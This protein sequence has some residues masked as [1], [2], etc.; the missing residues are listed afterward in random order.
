MLHAR[1]L[2][3]LDEVARTGSI[4]QAAGRLNV[5]ASAIN[6]QILALEEEIG[7]PLFHR[8]PRKLALTAA[9]E[10]LIRHIRQTLREERAAQEKIEALKGLHGGEVS[11]ALMSGLAANVV[12]RAAEAFR[13]AHPRAKLALRL[14]PTGEDIVAAISEGEADLGLGFDFPAA[15]RLR[16]LARN[17]GRLGCVMAP[18]HPFAARAELRIGDCVEQPLVIADQSMVIRPYLDA[19]FAKAEMEPRI[20]VE[21]NAIEVMRQAAMR[22]LGITFLTPF[23][24]EADRAAGRLVYV[25]VREL[26]QRAQTLMLIGAERGAT[27]LASLFAETIM[28]LIRPE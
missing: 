20:A 8:L 10:V 6:R 15:A 5:A 28:E 1:L 12:P 23:D 9:G 16:V 26:A 18:D 2:T 22:G 21:T 3:Y 19:L 4:R 25:P 7:T 14:L 13:R 24:I 27:P 11:L 17:T